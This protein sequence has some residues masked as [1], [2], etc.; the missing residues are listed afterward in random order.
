MSRGGVNTFVLI[1]YFLNDKWE[2]CYITVNFFD[3]VDTSRSS[4]VLQ[5]N[6]VLENMG[7][8]FLFLHMSKMKG[9]IS[10]HYI[11]INLTYV[12][13]NFGIVETFCRVMLGPRNVQMLS[14]CHK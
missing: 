14:I 5:V 1:M 10:H 12:S 8:K 9:V 3:I 6:N 2:P 13:W 11:Y 4:M 7:L